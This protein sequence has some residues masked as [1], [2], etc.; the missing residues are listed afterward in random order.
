[1]RFTSV[2]VFLA[3]AATAGPFDGVYRLTANSDCGLIGVDGGAIAIEDGLFRGVESNCRM[4]NPVQILEMNAKL[5][6]LHCTGEGSIWS[7]R[8]MLM[9]KATGDGI[10]MI[11]DGYAFVYDRCPAE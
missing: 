4:E 1:M 10:L 5:Y 7:E 9:E 8:V 3:G 6:N 11:W 2:F